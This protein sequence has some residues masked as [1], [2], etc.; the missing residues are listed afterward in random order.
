MQQNPWWRGAVI[1]QVYP[2]SMMDSNNDGIGDIPGIISKLDYIASLGV[3]AIWISPFFKSPM[4]DFGYDISDYRAIDPIFGTLADFDELIVQAHARNIKIIIDQVLNHTSDQHAWFEESRES[5]DNPKADWYVWAD[6]NPDG[7]PP[8]NWLSI[9]GGSAWEWEP[10]RCQYYL[11]NFLK[12]QPDL[13]YHCPALREQILQEV[14]FWLKR[15]VDGLRLDAIIF[16][17]HDKQL[18]SNPAKPVE[19]RKGRGF[20]EDNPYAFQRH[21]HDTCQ[22]ENIGFLESLRSL[23]NRYPGTVTLGEIASEDSLKTMA[24]Y[25]AGNTRL[26]M[27]YSFELLVDNLSAS[28]IRETV[29]TLEKNL[30]DGWP[31]WAFGNHDVVRVMSRW[32]GE[33]HAPAKAKLLNE[34]LFSLRGS[35]CS[36]QGEELGLTEAE[37][38]QHELQDPYGITFWPRFKG[39]DGCRTPMPWSKSAINA[40]F[41]QGKTWLPVSPEHLPMAVDLQDADKNS[42]LH[43]FRKFLAWRKQQPALLWGDIE[44]LDAPENVLL[45]VRT[46]EG[47]RL[48]AAFNLSAVTETVNLGGR[49]AMPIKAHDEVSAQC[50]GDQ[51]T[52]SPYAS[53][54][55]SLD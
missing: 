34:L 44:F 47:Q 14:E 37:I 7:T 42:V 39:R 10:R 41:S 29:E 54:F 43:A 32:K 46:Y 35:V 49:K 27:T 31:C 33:E 36:Y 13:N 38:A 18:R 9:F 5:K 48:L 28:Y 22:P 6:A 17:F 4:K 55:A 45:F 21:V 30:T 24:E 19:E 20:R 15:G 50:N 1:Y 16:C 52:L 51:L 8:N 3:D 40:G 11:H 26:H 23:M 53:F 25:T 2:R 12:T